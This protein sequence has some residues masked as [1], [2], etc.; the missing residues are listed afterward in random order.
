LIGGAFEDVESS[1][2]VTFS[3]MRV[4]IVDTMDTT[5]KY[6]I[7]QPAGCTDYIESPCEL[8]SSVSNG[9]NKPPLPPNQIKV[10]NFFSQNNVASKVASSAP[11]SP[12]ANKLPPTYP[13]KTKNFCKT[14]IDP[15]V[16]S[17]VSIN[18]ISAVSEIQPIIEEQP[19]I[20]APRER[21]VRRGKGTRRNSIVAAPIAEKRKSLVSQK[22]EKSFGHKKSVS[23]SS[24][25]KQLKSMSI[26][27]ES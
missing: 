7:K 6:N 14:F 15:E 5:P 16:K 3:M 18:T 8:G 26:C 1:D 10:N 20:P 23:I 17:M 25:P 2:D 13:H 12:M 4:E 27:G 9:P 22:S 11:G 21:K 19:I 24:L